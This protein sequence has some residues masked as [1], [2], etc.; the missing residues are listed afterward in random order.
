MTA[1]KRIIAATALTAA[2]VSMPTAVNATYSAH[3]QSS[4]PI[5]SEAKAARKTYHAR[6][7][8]ESQSMDARA[9][10]TR[11]ALMAMVVAVQASCE[12]ACISAL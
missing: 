1:F 12:G 9:R 2:C 4:A 3:T 8:I 7:M 11:K 6:Q 10:H 5:S